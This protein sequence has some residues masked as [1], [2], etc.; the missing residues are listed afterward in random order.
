MKRQVN[1]RVSDATRAKLDALTA[2]Y[3]TQAEAI[4]VAI[5]RM[6]KQEMAEMKK[7]L[8]RIEAVHAEVIPIK[9]TIK[10]FPL[11]YSLRVTLRHAGKTVTVD[12]VNVLVTEQQSEDWCRQQC[13][14][15]QDVLTSAPYHTPG[16]IIRIIGGLGYQALAALDIPVP[17][18]R[19]NATEE[20][21]LHYA[22]R[23]GKGGIYLANELYQNW[24]RAYNQW[25]EE[26]SDLAMDYGL[27]PQNETCLP[28]K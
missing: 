10:G 24:V 23:T 1:I 12:A 17:P 15:L 16:E 26:Y 14:N 19:T 9:V 13:K 6:C 21:K 8:P 5:D 18:Q 7:H 27:T 2:R 20:E 28:V 11:G 22:Q 25:I 3:G 4:A